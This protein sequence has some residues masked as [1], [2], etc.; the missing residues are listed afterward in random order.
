MKVRA[1]ALGI[2]TS[3]TAPYAVAVPSWHPIGPAPIADGY[4]AHVECKADVSGRASA[5][6]VNPVDPREVFLGTANGGVWLSNDAGLSWTP[7]S[8]N[9]AS[10][11]IGAVAVDDCAGPLMIYAGTGE[12]SIRRD[13]YSGAG[14]L[15]MDRRVGD[16][17]AWVRRG[18]QF[19]RGSINNIV[20]DPTTC[21]AQGPGGTGKRLYITVSS[22]VTASASEST[23]TAP[24]PAD[25]Y[26]IWKSEDTG[27]NWHRLDVDGADPAKPTDLEMDPRTP[28]RLYAGFMGRGI[29]LTTNAG[30]TWCPLNPGVPLPAGC[31]AKADTGLP[32]VDAAPFDHV[33]IAIA[34]SNP[35]VLYALFGL[36]TDP[37]E[38]SC[39]SLLY[40][41][42]NGGDTWTRTHAAEGCDEE[43]PEG[44]SR[45]TH[46]L[47]VHPD[48]SNVLFY[49]G[50]GL[51]RT[52]DAGCTFDEIGVD[53]DD[54]GCYDEDPEIAWDKLHLDQHA[55]VFGDPGGDTGILYSATDGGFAWSRDG[56]ATWFSGNDG[57]QITGFQSLSSS[58]LTDL[59]MGGSQDNGT[60]FWTG[61]RRWAQIS[62]G[63]TGST[64]M[65]LDTEGRAYQYKWS[66][67]VVVT[68]CVSVSCPFQDFDAGLAEDDAHA[69]YPPI[70]Q[71]PSEPHG[72]YFG[73]D[74][75]YYNPAES[76]DDDWVAFSPVLCDSDGTFNDIGVKNVVT[77]IAV[78]P[79]NPSRIYVGCYD[80]QIW[81]RDVGID[82]T[83][84]DGLDEGWPRAPVT[85][86]AVEPS[87][88]FHG[89]RAYAAF[90]GF[91][92]GSRLRVTPD[93]GATWID[94][95]GA[96]ATALPDVPVNTVHIED[97][98]PFVISGNVW[99]G[100]DAGVFRT[101]DGGLTW[102]SVNEGLP[103]VAVYEIS[104]DPATGRV[105]AGTHGR[106]AFVFTDPFVETEVLCEDDE[107]FDV[108]RVRSL[109]VRG[110]GFLSNRCCTMQLVQADGTVCAEGADGA[111][112]LACDGV[113]DEDA[114]DSLMHTG[115]AGELVGLHDEA[116]RDFL[117]ACFGG[118]CLGGIP[119]ADCDEFGNRLARVR[120]NCEGEV[121]E[122][123]V[124]PCRRERRRDSASHDF[125]RE[126]RRQNLL[127]ASPGGSFHLIPSIQAS[128]GTTRSLC[129]V[130]VPFAAEEPSDDVL[131]AAR[132]A[133]NGNETCRSAGVSSLVHGI[134]RPAATGEEDEFVPPTNLTLDAPD[135]TGTLLIPSLHAAPGAAT[136]PCFETDALGD[137]LHGLMTEMRLSFETLPTGAAGGRVTIEERSSAG[138]CSITTPTWP[139]EA[140]Q[141]IAAQVA[142]RFRSTGPDDPRCPARHNARDVFPQGESIVTTMA[143]RIV[144]C[145]KDPGV[146]FS[147]KPQALG[148]V[149]PA[150]SAGP[151]RDVEC[152]SPQGATIVFD[153]TGSSDPDSV[154]LG[155][156]DISVAEW[157]EDHGLPSQRLLGTG[158]I[159]TATL[160]VGVHRV[161]LRVADSAGLAGSDEAIVR[162]VDTR[163]PHLTAS[164]SPAILW[165]PNHRMVTVAASVAASDE[166]GPP[167]IV[168]S[169]VRSDEADDAPGGADGKTQNDIQQAVT[170]TADFQFLLRA[171]RSSTADG[172]TYT[173]TY[174]A[175][176]GAG[177]V[178]TAAAVAVVPLQRNGVVEPV[179]LDVR[180]TPAGTV[181]TWGLV[182][183]A[184]GYDLVRGDLH[185][186]VAQPGNVGLGPV[187]CLP[188]LSDSQ[189]LPDPALPDPGRAFFYLVQY[190]GPE[191]GPASGGASAYGTESAS[192]PHVPGSGGC[193]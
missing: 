9:E 109:L 52:D 98:G 15:V 73:S 13:T 64:V 177:N 108:G 111:A 60:N 123:R 103:N 36:C 90:S 2:A 75:L 93:G 144:V 171:E 160:P 149:H 39:H 1:L 101:L 40:R 118:T 124:R 159:V 187:V 4:L 113:P 95:S 20:L 57:L 116:D 176:D 88:L 54:P 29:F 147:L 25:R 134:P 120:V 80:G 35:D 167:S 11:A 180:Q 179:V 5:I 14:L 133:V 33:E 61:T 8:D 137:P 97:L 45:Y 175:T 170:G 164:L 153:G 96:G 71:D 172:R 107:D 83:R 12:N 150:A 135:V 191:A 143:S 110:G 148:N 146:G 142:S 50:M 68:P 69:F 91:D 141:Q 188:R 87:D 105:Y 17:P 92:V 62:G 78:A 58:P 127:A 114:N 136:G 72:L 173:A 139:G 121:A 49:G 157:F 16:L 41:S 156:D 37:L 63:D 145:V 106:G 46:V 165:P 155:H 163:P 70:V 185:R 19:T 28:S 3:L 130:R 115:A 32:D 84:V 190:H 10:L 182:P 189:G 79:R 18:S 74:R 166:C 27:V 23:V 181:V 162:V 67:H 192:M 24:L 125:R 100:T 47:T 138:S 122:G 38:S 30:D 66:G 161:T 168:L 85:R 53:H 7:M 77:A 102:E 174:T 82:W 117:W 193:E 178:A 48:D 43:L 86:I 89:E 154:S 158:R 112:G 56:G 81:T 34:P 22:G 44:Y 99:V 94:V 152:A 6:A 104:L 132:D 65:D 169:D 131:Q 129:T 21:H 184:T 186:I 119:V 140:A 31:P 26:G 51:H 126:G 42:D 128:D 151:D 76:I 55:L 183:E 59:V